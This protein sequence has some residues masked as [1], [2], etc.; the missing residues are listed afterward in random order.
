MLL[1]VLS[2][3]TTSKAVITALAIVQKAT[4]HSNNLMIKTIT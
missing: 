4:P 2:D 1:A 3:D